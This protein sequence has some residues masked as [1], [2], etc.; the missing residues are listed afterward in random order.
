[1]PETLFERQRQLA[2]HVRDPDRHPAPAGMDRQRLAVYRRLF[3]GNLD[4]LLCGAFPVLHECLPRA[5]WQALVADF[6]ARYPCRTPLFTEVAGEFIDYLE[7]RLE[8]P[9]WIA[10]LAHYEGLET[11]LLLSDAQAPAHDPQGDLLSGIPL[12]S[13]L[14]RPLAYRWPVSELMPGAVPEQPPSEPTLLLAHRDA[15]GD[16]RFSRLAP[17]AHAL[18]LA[19]GQWQLSGREHLQALAELTGAKPQALIPQGLALLEQLRD[20]GALLGTWRN[21]SR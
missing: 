18:L 13:P 3:L 1:M 2:S 20:Q 10:E 19:I 16:V 15:C 17:L 5:E 8:L 7:G 14:A 9:G 6:Y 11:A 4:G 21:G 12:L